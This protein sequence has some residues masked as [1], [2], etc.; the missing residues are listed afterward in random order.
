MSITR[1]R[2]DTRTTQKLFY[3]ECLDSGGCLLFGKYRGRSAYDIAR[4]D[5]KYLQWLADEVE[6]ID[7]KDRELLLQLLETYG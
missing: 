7:E 6:D 5:P 1:N 4:S 3:R 2:E